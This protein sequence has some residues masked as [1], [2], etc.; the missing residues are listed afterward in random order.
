MSS[1]LSAN[2]MFV[3]VKDFS[4]FMY[5]VKYNIPRGIRSLNIRQ[6][7]ANVYNLNSTQSAN[8]CKSSMTDLVDFMN[9]QPLPH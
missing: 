5:R 3:E 8:F 9:Q 2:G 7:A 1:G 4:L 6:W